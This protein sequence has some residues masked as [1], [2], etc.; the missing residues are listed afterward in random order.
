MHTALGPSQAGQLQ[1]QPVHQV[2]DGGQL[3]VGRQVYA[4]VTVPAV[5]QFAAG[6]EAILGHVIQ[7]KV[8]AGEHEAGSIADHPAVELQAA[9]EIFAALKPLEKLADVPVGG[10]QCNIVLKVPAVAMQ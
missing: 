7:H 10:I 4:A 5:G 6:L 8:R 9:G 3:A 1:V 2:G